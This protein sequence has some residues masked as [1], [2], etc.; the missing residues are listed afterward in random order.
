MGVAAEEACTDFECLLFQ[1]RALLDRFALCI[2]RHHGGEQ[3]RF[4]RLGKRLVK[5]AD[6]DR[7]A[8]RLSNILKQ[9]VGL[10]GPLTDPTGERSLRSLLA[11]RSSFSEGTRV[12]FWV[13]RLKDGRFLVFDCEVHHYSVFATFREIFKLV[14]FVVANGLLI[15]TGHDK[16]LSLSQFEPTWK[17]PFVRLSDYISESE[18]G[19]LVPVG[20]RFIP[21]GIRTKSVYLGRSIF[22]RAITLPAPSTKPC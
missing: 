6:A 18:T 19:D 3:D 7:R 8:G 11:H 5:Y 4:S 2:D 16:Q 12:L 13:M 9:A 17:V 14:P 22:D 15:Y 1:A 10:A 21:N 20:V